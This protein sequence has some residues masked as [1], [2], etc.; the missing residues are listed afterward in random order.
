MLTSKQS[1]S[2]FSAVISLFW[3]ADKLYGCCWC[4]VAGGKLVLHSCLPIGKTQARDTDSLIR[5][6]FSKPKTRQLQCT[7]EMHWNSLIYEHFIH[8]SHNCQ[9]IALVFLVSSHLTSCLPGQDAL[10]WQFSP[11]C[12]CIPSYLL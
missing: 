12:S 8:Q 11:S 10:E 9:D 6:L 1:I 3:H 2:S 4:A 7:P 5:I